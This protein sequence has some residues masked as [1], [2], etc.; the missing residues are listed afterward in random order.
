MGISR[1]AQNKNNGHKN[2]KHDETDPH[3]G[4]GKRNT[5]WHLEPEQCIPQNQTHWARRGA[6][7]QR[8]MPHSTY[9]HIMMQ[10]ILNYTIKISIW[11]RRK[12][13][14]YHVIQHTVMATPTHGMYMFPRKSPSLL[15]KMQH[16]MYM[17]IN[18]VYGPEPSLSGGNTSFNPQASAPTPRPVPNGTERMCQSHGSN[19]TP[20]HTPHPALVQNL[21]HNLSTYSYTCSWG[22]PGISHFKHRNFVGIAIEFILF[23]AQWPE[24]TDGPQWSMT[25][26]RLNRGDQSQRPYPQAWNTHPRQHCRLCIYIYKPA[27]NNNQ[28]PGGRKYSSIRHVNCSFYIE[29][30]T[31]PIPVA[32]PGL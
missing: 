12:E 24:H 8:T 11:N 5:Q 14:Q 27:T 17:M 22:V 25:A 21:L 16:G 7:D 13:Q 28:I 20:T 9:I 3:Q 4:I 6:A 32:F 31:L 2:P 1:G 18:W 19:H 15:L 30:R 29:R 26:C 23:A 10:T